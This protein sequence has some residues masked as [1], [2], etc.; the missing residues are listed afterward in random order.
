MSKH[1]SSLVMIQVLPLACTLLYS[2]PLH[3]D[4]HPAPP[5]DEFLDSPL[6]GD[7][8]HW[9]ERL[10]KSGV[11]I[12]ISQISD[13]VGNRGGNQQGLYYDGLLVPQVDANLER[14]FGWGG[15]SLHLSGYVIQGQGITENGNHR[16]F[17]TPTNIEYTPAVTK[18]GEL[19]FQQE[20][21][22]GRLALK[23]GQIEADIN[24]NTNS[25]SDFFVNSTWG[26]LGIWSANL[27]GSGPTYPNPVP[28]IQVILTPDPEWTI[29]AAV[30]NGNPTGNDP[31][32]NTNGL[33]F[34]VGQGALTFMELAYEPR[35]P[36]SEA[37]LSHAYKLGAWYNSERFYSL[38]TAANGLP[39][40]DPDASVEPK[41]YAGNYA[42][43]ATLDQPIWYETNTRGQG[44]NIFGT[45]S[46]NPQVDRNL[47]EWLFDF[48][49]TYTGLIGGR[50]RDRTGIGF[51]R[52]NMSPAYAKNVRSFNDHMGTT[53]A[54]PSHES[55]LELTH[56]AVIRP[57]LR[58]QPFFQYLVNPGQNQFPP[59]DYPDLTILGVR[60]ILSL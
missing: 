3:A 51:T 34:P 31:L 60:F 12:D 41:T 58:I 7:W 57:W 54:I 47:A 32:G 27:P 50:P 26:W 25:S 59:M 29:Q 21:F 19:W 36:D 20:F 22:E 53:Y 46:I 4:T 44:L 30:F 33:R 56:Q 28:A 6:S 35:S 55:F 1:L 2:Y 8:G 45:F 40:N 18:L 16:A 14:L 37:S 48:G 42:L 24:F 5:D 9:R 52:L 15:A 49:L 38:T 17:L 10:E 39:L 13:L 43:Y 11:T 23:L